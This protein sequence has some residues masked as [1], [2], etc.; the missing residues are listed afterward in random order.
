M[1]ALELGGKMV[2]VKVKPALFSLCQV[3]APPRRFG[4]VLLPIAG[5]VKRG[6]RGF[7]ERYSCLRLHAVAARHLVAAILANTHTTMW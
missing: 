1:Q 6:E 2:S 5:S 3:D 4:S 7:Q